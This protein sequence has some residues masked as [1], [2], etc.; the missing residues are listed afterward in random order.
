MGISREHG[1]VC[2]SVCMHCVCMYGWMDG[3]LCASVYV[4]GVLGFGDQGP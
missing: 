1:S 3:H 4:L 2:L